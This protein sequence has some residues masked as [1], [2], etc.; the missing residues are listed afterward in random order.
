[1]Y[2]FLLLCLII[3]CLFFFFFFFFFNDTATTEIYTLSLHDALP[4]PFS[5]LGLDPLEC[6]A[7]IRDLHQLGR[8]R[9]ADADLVLEQRFPFVPRAGMVGLERLEVLAGGDVV[10]LGLV[11]G[12]VALGDVRLDGFD[13]LRFAHDAALIL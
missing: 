3:L 8:S 9:L 2:V 13:K 6:L 1:M 10:L 4:I 11:L 12:V 5:P 7:A